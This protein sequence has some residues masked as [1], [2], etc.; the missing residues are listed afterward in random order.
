MPYKDKRAAFWKKVDV[1]DPN[2]CWIWQRAKSPD[3]YGK[4]LYLGE[5]LAH[6]AA[7]KDTYG[8]IPNGFCVLHSCDNPACVNPKHL[9]LG[10]RDD[11][12]ADRNAK[13][14]QARG[15]RHGSVTKP[16]TCPRGETHCRAKLTTLDV[17][18]IR[19]FYARG[20]ISQRALAE[21]FDV[22]HSTVGAIVRGEMRKEG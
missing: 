20:G 3:G 9:F 12:M 2:D 10:T 5:Q 8:E 1:G 4:C 11:N 19:L 18:M 14:R 16:E 22:T 7:W 21:D 17:N 15:K 6:R 13:G